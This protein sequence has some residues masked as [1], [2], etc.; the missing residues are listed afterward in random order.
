MDADVVKLVCPHCAAAVVD[1]GRTCPKCGRALE[2][3][4]RRNAQAAPISGGESGAD[5]SL[6]ASLRTAFELEAEALRTPGACRLCGA[7]GSSAA[8]RHYLTAPGL[9]AGSRLGDFEILGELGRGGMGIVYRARQLSLGREVAL[10]VLPPR[11]ARRRTAVQRFRIE[12]QA[13]A[14][15]HHTNIVAVHAQGEHSGCF[16]YAMELVEGVGLDTVIHSRRD[17][18]SSTHARNGSSAGRLTEKAEP[19]A[20]P[21]D[22]A[23]AEVHWTNQDYRHVAA[24]MAEVADALACAHRHSVIHRDVKPHNL[25]LGTN[26]RLHLTDFGLARLTD[27]PHLTVS[28]EVMGTPAYL[29]PEQ[30]RG[31]GTEIDHRTDIYSLGVTLYEVL[32]R[33]K[34]FGGQTR[35]EI[36][37]GICTAEPVPPR[38]LDPRIPV[39]LET[40][41]RRAIEKDP[42][43]RHPSAA[44]LAEDLRRF[45]EG[46]AILSRR[47]SRLEK[48]LRWAAR[49]KSLTAAA[50]VIAAAGLLSA[51]LGWTAHA[52]RQREAQRLV[53]DA[54]EQLAYVDYHAPELVQADI[55]RAAALGADPADLDLARALA[56]LGTNDEPDAIHHLTAILQR[57][58]TDQRTQY[59]L[60]WA[61]W[62][63]G[64]H[65]AARA[66]FDLAEQHGPP[67]AADAWFFRGLAMHFDEPLTAIESYRQANTVR[68]RDHA[69]YPQAV[70]HLARARNQ[71]VYTARSLDAFPEAV[72]SLRQLIEHEQYGAYP[73]YLLSISHRLAA[74]IY[75]GSSGT[76]GDSL[77]AEHYA[78]A[79]EWARV[80]QGADPASDRP[81]TAEAEC[82]ES[83]GRYAQ[84]IEA[85]TRAIELAGKGIR[86]W[87]GYHYRWRLLYWTGELEAALEDV[88]MAADYDPQCPFYAHVYPALIRAEMGD[89][90]AALAHARALAA[91]APNSAQ[92]VL[93]SATCLRLLGR[94]EEAETLLA[95][96]ADAVDFA[97]ELVPPQSEE[98]M[99]A[100]Y[101]HCRAG[102]HLAELEALAAE[103]GAP[104]RLWG[105]AQFHAA[106]L[107]LS[108]GDRAGAL[109]GF[110]RAYRCFDG[111]RRYTY[112]AKLICN[113]MQSDPAWP[114]WIA[115]SAR[116]PRLPPTAG[117]AERFVAPVRDEEGER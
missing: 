15:L 54:Y 20:S 114:G 9:S 25:L 94:P 85:R 64:E 116:D 32:T 72:A 56:C 69:L 112:H 28:G 31:H 22:A 63:N 8:S 55:D 38:R 115:A 68:A 48:A 89:L 62:R 4:V 58:P 37:A 44:K 10:K 12:A 96:R 40:I 24:L 41:C 111:E 26:N 108:A 109:V 34:P 76:R 75:S 60:A 1:P 39:E 73:Y 49:H 13:A 81:V 42:R 78:Q 35:E 43:R 11:G 86:R 105:E 99:R 106:A 16:Y 52:A 66:T 45:S 100:L 5:K 19:A 83:M 18:L 82:L 91:E 3:A 67:A 2:P 95:D 77:V 117:A 93:W 61:Q 90:P 53:R 27:G 14:R 6:V 98:W 101:A 84:A 57:D 47:P 70:L 46:R 30:V 79:L 97:A 74:E 21:A 104:W 7:A 51:G 102:G 110:Q 71:Q 59:L 87:E 103:A 92:A 33:R 23:T 88:A 17:L 107:R 50:V 113:R 36:L 65:A 80:G 29:S